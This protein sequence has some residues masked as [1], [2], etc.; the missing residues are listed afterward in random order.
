MTAI[1]IFEPLR[2]EGTSSAAPPLAAPPP[3]AATAG[4]FTLRRS[5]ARP[6]SFAGRLLGEAS[7]WRPGLALW[8]EL[9]LYRCEDGRHVAEIR[10]RGKAPGARD[11]FHVALADSLE[12][13]VLV[14]ETHDPKADVA[15]ELDLDDPALAPAELLV[16]AAALR[17]RIAEAVSGYRATVAGF[18]HGLN[19]N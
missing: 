2:A 8:H 7:G 3:D 14:F 16:Q 9:A 6:V 10:A 18:L 13:A 15:A 1:Q 5:G 17:C 12:D 4:C 19:G 11:Q